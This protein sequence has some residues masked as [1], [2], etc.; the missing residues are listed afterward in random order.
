MYFH[1][2]IF[3]QQRFRQTDHGIPRPAASPD[4]VRRL[5]EPLGEFLV[6]SGASARDP[7]EIRSDTLVSVNILI[8]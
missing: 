4:V 3:T 7:G 2:H 5:F 1:L 8:A 6:T